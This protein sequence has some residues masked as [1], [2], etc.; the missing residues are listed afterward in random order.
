MPPYCSKEGVRRRSRRL[1]C[2]KR[3]LPAASTLA[4]YF[5]INH[6]VSDTRDEAQH[7]ATNHDSSASAL[8]AGSITLSKCRTNP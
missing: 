1:V 3:A 4:A 2:S 8:F 6:Q 5:T 7:S